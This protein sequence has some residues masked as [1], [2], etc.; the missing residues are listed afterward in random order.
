[1]VN[2][3]L[4][5]LE[6]SV[7]MALLLNR[8]TASEVAVPIGTQPVRWSN[9]KGTKSITGINVLLDWFALSSGV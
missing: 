9:T 5:P 6:M 8:R 2:G 7:W 3:N 4:K 1:M